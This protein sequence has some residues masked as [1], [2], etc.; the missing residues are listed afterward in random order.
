MPPLAPPAPP[1]MPPPPPSHQTS[2]SA[3]V[4]GGVNLVLSVCG[5]VAG[6]Y[7]LL[8]LLRFVCIKRRDAKEASVKTWLANEG[9]IKV[10]LKQK[11]QP[12]EE[13][14]VPRSGSAFSLLEEAEQ[15]AILDRRRGK[16]PLP[17]TAAAG[18]TADA[19][20]AAS[21]DAAAKALS[22]SP[23]LLAGSRDAVTDKGAL[24]AEAA[25]AAGAGAALSPQ[26]VQRQWLGS[27]EGGA[28]AAAAVPPGLL[29]ALVPSESP[30]P[31]PGPGRRHRSPSRSSHRSSSHR[32]SPVTGDDSTSPRRQ[33][34]EG[35]SSRRQSDGGSSSRRQSGDGDHHRRRSGEE[36]SPRRQS[37]EGISTRDGN[38]L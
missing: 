38:R 13:A 17:R 2:N 19:D 26:E 15:R 1:R 34:G 16:V 22:V 29:R 37:G 27:L 32:S 21:R 6:G 25:E 18:A 24:L 14:P 28:P 23:H 5:I 12:D 4:V 9:V 10:K 36:A 31:A 7:V 20:S 3:D 11:G 30:D 8:V 33:S 35:T